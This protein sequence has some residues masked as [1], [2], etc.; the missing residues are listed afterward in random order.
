KWNWVY[1]DMKKYGYHNQIHFDYRRWPQ[2]GEN[3]QLEFRSNGKVYLTENGKTKHGRMEITD[4][5]I[6]NSVGASIEGRGF[7]KIQ[8]RFSMANTNPDTIRVYEFPFSNW[9]QHIPVNYFVREQ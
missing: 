6:G 1:S 4:Q 3:Y 2:N 5:T 9:G 8:I 7:S